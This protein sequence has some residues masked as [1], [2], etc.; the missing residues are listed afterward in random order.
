MT[1]TANRVRP[2][3]D[4]SVLERGVGNVFSQTPQDGVEVGQEVKLRVRSRVKVDGF[5]LGKTK[6]LV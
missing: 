1:G 3:N 5:R 4:I 6:F 2:E